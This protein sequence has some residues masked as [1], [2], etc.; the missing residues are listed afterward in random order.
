MRLRSLAL[1]GAAGLATLLAA[2]ASP[3][4]PKGDAVHI[5]PRAALGASGDTDDAGR[6]TRGT[7][8]NPDHWQPG[9]DVDMVDGTFGKP[10]PRETVAYG[11][12]QPPGTV[13]VSTRER[14]LYL[15]LA[16]GQAIRYGVGVGRPGFAWTGGQTIT[17]KREWPDWTPPAAMIKRRPEIPHHMAG[18]VD[19]PLGARALYLGSTEF[20]IHGSNEPDTIGQAVSSGCIRMTNADVADLY[21]H[22]KVG[23]RVVVQP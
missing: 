23:T 22:V 19:N 20:R 13:V 3:L 9:A 7:L 15:V 2:E 4:P 10:V 8:V 5:E 14:R 21:D 6:D 11:G 12:Q 18:G 17:A 16:D 1:A